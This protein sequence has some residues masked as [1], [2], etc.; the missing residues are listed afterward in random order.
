MRIEKFEIK[1][2]IAKYIGF[3]KILGILYNRLKN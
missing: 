2:N 3:L 1:I